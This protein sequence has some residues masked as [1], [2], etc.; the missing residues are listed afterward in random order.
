VGAHGLCGRDGHRPL[1][2]A[3]KE[4]V[5]VPELLERELL[6]SQL[7]EGAVAITPEALLEREVLVSPLG[8]R[9]HTGEGVQT[10][11]HHLG[12]STGQW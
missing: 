2:E 12:V 7:G 8:V 5:V 4:G 6:V 9:V 11:F 10:W 3:G 1:A